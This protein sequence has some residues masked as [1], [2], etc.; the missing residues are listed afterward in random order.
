MKLYLVRHG[1]TAHNRDGVGLGRSDVPLTGRGRQQGASL[2]SRF[3]GITFDAAYASPLV[4][5]MDTA[6]AALEGSGVT[7]EPSHALIEL[8]V[9]ET[10]GMT[11]PDMRERHADFL[12]E[13]A[14]PDGHLVRFP[15]GERLQ[16]VDD[17]VGAFLAELR[18]A[19]PGNVLVV[20]HNFVLRLLLCRLLGL[21]PSG[22]RNII[23]GLASL[24]IVEVDDDRATVSVINDTC[25]LSAE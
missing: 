14:G 15:G 5:A 6:L 11:F 13:W 24:S 2:R 7:P 25:H 4:R 18:S 3:E 1:E 21:P 16:D 17:R 9:G 23:V 8:D 10:E 12:R 22:F 20:S 19:S